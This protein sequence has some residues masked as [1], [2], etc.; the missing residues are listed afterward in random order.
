MR[1]W[2]QSAP[3]LKSATW[4]KAALCLCALAMIVLGTAPAAFA[5][6]DAPRHQLEF[7]KTPPAVPAPNVS[8]EPEI[9][10]T[11]SAQALTPSSTRSIAC[12]QSTRM[13]LPLVVA[14]LDRSEPPQ[15]RPPI[16]A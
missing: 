16:G 6:S 11:D 7:V 14:M 1:L 8:D 5:A 10:T 15:L 2:L 4:L 13:G 3:W 12:D 9:T